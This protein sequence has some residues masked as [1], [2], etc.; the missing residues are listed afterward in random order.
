M[1]GTVSP[2]NVSMTTNPT[3]DQQQ[4]CNHFAEAF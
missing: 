4:A 3:G 1:S 2:G